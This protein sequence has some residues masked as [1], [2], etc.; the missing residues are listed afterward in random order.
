MLI[1]IVLAPV[2]FSEVHAKMSFFTL[3]SATI[4][5]AGTFFL[6]PERTSLKTALRYKIE[7]R[8]ILF[9]FSKLSFSRII[10]TMIGYAALLIFYYLGIV[11][12]FFLSLLF[13]IVIVYIIDFL[14][15]EKIAKSIY[16]NK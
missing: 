10:I 14:S 1:L 2:R 13:T 4:L 9:R 5:L 16:E 7:S 12:G 8:K 11:P 3:I 6:V 15:I